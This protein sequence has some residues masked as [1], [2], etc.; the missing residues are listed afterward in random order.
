MGSIY[1]DIEK[2]YASLTSTKKQ[3]VIKILNYESKIPQN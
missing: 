1:A 2:L 3:T